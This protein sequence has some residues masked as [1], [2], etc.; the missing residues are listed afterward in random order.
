MSFQTEGKELL[1]RHKELF[2]KLILIP[3]SRHLIYHEELDNNK[4]IGKPRFKEREFDWP[5]DLLI[6]LRDHLQE[7]WHYFQLYSYW[8]D[9]S[10]LLLIDYRTRK[11]SKK[12][13]IF[14]L[15]MDVW[16]TDEVYGDYLIMKGKNTTKIYYTR[17]LI[18]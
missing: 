2:E 11:A 8:L 17:Q 18:I 5:Q 4:L 13:I 12:S 7:L 10:L 6:E 3:E 16:Q 9:S 15:E 14:L 1:K